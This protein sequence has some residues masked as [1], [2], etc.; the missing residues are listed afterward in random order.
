M[1]QF[2]KTFVDHFKRQPTSILEIGSRD[3]E[4]AEALRA[5]ADIPHELVNLVE[6]HPI[7]FRNMINKYPQ[8]KSFNLAISDV[9]GVIR[10]NAIPDIYNLHIM[11]CSSILEISKEHDPDYQKYPPPNWIK[12]LAVTGRTILELIDRF[13][14]DLVKIDVEGLTYEA[15]KSFGPDIRLL[16]ALHIEV[17]MFELWEGQHLYHEIQQY[18][19]NWGFAEAYYIPLWWSGRQGDSVWL[20]LD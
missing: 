1:E 8:A 9:P 19:T 7:N 20:R 6:P 3:G 10:F 2:Y 17:E 4:H 15:L 11:G 16:K 13:E 12:V 5:L 18:L 14:I